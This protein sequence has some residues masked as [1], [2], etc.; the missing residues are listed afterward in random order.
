ML[1]YIMNYLPKLKARLLLLFSIINFLNA[2]EMLVWEQ[3][4]KSIGVALRNKV[5]TFY[6][7]NTNLL[8]GITKILNC[9]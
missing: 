4:E 3:D 6:G 5:E 2:G 9:S 8:S 7:A 1:K